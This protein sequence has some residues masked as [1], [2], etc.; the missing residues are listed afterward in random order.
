[1][2]MQPFK[3]GKRKIRK[4]GNSYCICIPVEWLTNKGIGKGDEV[5]VEM[6]EEGLLIRPTGVASVPAPQPTS[7]QQTPHEL[8][9]VPSPVPSSPLAARETIIPPGEDIKTPSSNQNIIPGSE[10]A[11]AAATALAIAAGRMRR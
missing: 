8:Q 2:D 1:M 6:I 5:S 10:Q 4:T 3:F 7:K 11:E 9:P